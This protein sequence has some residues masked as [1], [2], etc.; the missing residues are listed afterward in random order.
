MKKAIKVILSL[1]V[2]FLMFS[3]PLLFALIFS[4]LITFSHKPHTVNSEYRS[5]ERWQ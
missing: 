1:S 3:L 2:L 5:A 4:I